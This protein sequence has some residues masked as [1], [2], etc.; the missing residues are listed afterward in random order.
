MRARRLDKRR[1]QARQQ[2]L[3]FLLRHG[4]SYEAGKHW[5]QR[6]RSWLAGQTFD[7]SA[8]QIVLQD[9]LEAVWT[10]QDRRDQLIGR[11][12][13]MAAHWSM[14]P[15]VEALRGLRDLDFIPAATRVNC[16]RQ[17][18]SLFN[19]LLGR[20]EQ[21]AHACM[22]SSICCFNIGW[23]AEKKSQKSSPID[24]EPSYGIS[25][26]S[27]GVEAEHAFVQVV[28]AIALLGSG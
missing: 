14:G 17:T 25:C 11:I 4:R 12:S 10:A 19:H 8:H 27:L 26:S 20:G 9:Y 21:R 23:I 15:L 22:A 13:S 18:A 28:R 2:L 24:I 5:T 6:R 7:Q 16:P 1:T 3:A